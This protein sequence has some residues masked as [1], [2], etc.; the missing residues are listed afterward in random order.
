MQK[1]YP[2][3]WIVNTPENS[4]H[5]RSVASLREACSR[6]TILE[7]RVVMCDRFHNLHVDL[8]CAR[9]VIPR[10]E[11]A[12]GVSEGTVRDIALISRVNKPVC[13]IVTGFEYDEN[14]EC[15]VILSRKAVQL[16]CLSEYIEKL[17]PGD[18]IDA[19]I[20]HL[21][22]FGAFADIGAGITSLIPVDAISV[23]RIDHPRDRFKT[24]Q[25]IKAVVAAFDE[26][27]RVSLSHRELLGTWEEN[28]CMFK[29]GE[30]VSGIIR[31]IEPYGIF[32]ELTPNLAGLAEP[33][34][35]AAVGQ[36]ASVY[37]KSLLPERMKI[38]LIIVDAF[39]AGYAP[40]PVRYFIDGGSL[41]FWRYSPENCEKQIFTRFSD[42]EDEM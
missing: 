23:S 3:G 5:M 30:T 12:V 2:E 4:Y 16:R 10:N 1:Y 18:V 7:S 22:Y 26:L 8:G 40:E 13:F 9:G 21:E 31:S 19:R 17:S 35:D 15:T 34:E 27:G 38:K 36:Q 41:S 42:D 14:G 29:A 11:G 24:G 28:A 6:G 32:V 20:T 25:D 39:D 37:I 33:Y